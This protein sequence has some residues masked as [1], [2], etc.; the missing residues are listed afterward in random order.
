MFIETSQTTAAV[1]ISPC[2][3]SSVF[4]VSLLLIF[5]P[6]FYSFV[7]QINMSWS[8]LYAKFTEMKLTLIFS[9]NSWYGSKQVY[10]SKMSENSFNARLQCF[11]SITAYIFLLL[12]LIDQ[13][14]LPIMLIISTK[15]RQ[16]YHTQHSWLVHKA[17]CRLKT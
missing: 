14:H 7:H 5:T 11:L 13:C 6:R 8:D 1:L 12:L 9:T 2:Y 15:S 10:F 16:V 17:L 3:L 4:C